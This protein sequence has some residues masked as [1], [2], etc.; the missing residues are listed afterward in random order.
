ML[1]TVVGGTSATA[2][3]ID[4]PVPLDSRLTVTVVAGVGP[5]WQEW[6]VEPDGAVLAMTYAPEAGY[7]DESTFGELMSLVGSDGFWTPRD[8]SDGSASCTDGGTVTVRMGDR[9][10]SAVSDCGVAQDARVEEVVELVQSPW[11]STFRRVLSA[12]AADRP[13]IALERS[14]GGQERPDGSVHVDGSGDLTWSGGTPYG[15]V[16][17]MPGP[18]RDALR[19]LLD[20]LA[21]VPVPATASCT[22]PTRYTV[23]VGSDPPFTVGECDVA[24][25]YPVPNPTLGVLVAMMNALLD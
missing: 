1:L 3:G 18:Q 7:L 13:L 24:L 25:M 15:A 23:R 19:L 17:P 14:G 16:T 22:Q 20:R 8:G 5:T 9:S 10:L 6:A 11:A 2:C 12:S 21:E 4:V